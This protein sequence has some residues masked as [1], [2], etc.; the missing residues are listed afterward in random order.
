MMGAA[1]AL[2]LA[3]VTGA[4]EDPISDPLGFS[5]TDANRAGRETLSA[6]MMSY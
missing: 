5:F 3:F 4:F 1:H 6:Q 2:E